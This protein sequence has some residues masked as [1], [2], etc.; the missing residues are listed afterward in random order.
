[1]AI[2]PPPSLRQRI[3]TALVCATWF[4]L[5]YHATNFYAAELAP[6]RH[7]FY[8]S[9]ELGIPRIDAFILPYQSID[10]LF[11]LA[12]LLCRSTA[13]LR[14]L[15]GRV[16]LAASLAGACFLAWPL[17]LGHVRDAGNGPF[18]PFFTALYACDRP[19]NLF[20]SLHVTFVVILRASF[21]RS[22]GGPWRV[23]MHAWLALITAS[24]VLVHQHHLADLVGGASL[25][26]LACYL[27]DPRALP[28]VR[29]QPTR[30]ALHLAIGHALASAGCLVGAAIGG[31][32]WWLLAWPSLALAV[33]ALGH[34]GL[35]SA[36]L[37][38]RAGGPSL[39]AAIVLLPW[40][41]AV[42]WSRRFWWWRADPPTQVADG[43]F[44][45]RIREARGWPGPVI[46][47]ASEH[48]RRL[49]AAGDHQRLQ[50]WDLGV[51]D[52][53]TLASAAAAVDQARARGPVLVCCALGR[54]RSALVAASWLL[55]TGRAASAE[56]ALAAVRQVRP[57]I[58][59][60]PGAIRALAGM[61]RPM[62]SC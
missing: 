54:G 24:T 18:A 44:V 19:H 13:D 1:M 3:A 53:R 38:P 4:N 51:P 56:A 2:D 16:V 42:R 21:S 14:A 25:G 28:A 9:W 12:F 50:L 35:G 30:A 10:L 22:L 47:C 59:P 36:V 61:P 43:V 20:P 27:I 45:G 29:V 11:G 32:W 40:L 17:E 34:A 60:A 15:A 57:W 41:A 23:A 55:A 6:V 5:I 46:D 26:L 7:A 49:P 37:S 48:R 8:W 33:V 62:P 58:T 52:S 39:A 31:G